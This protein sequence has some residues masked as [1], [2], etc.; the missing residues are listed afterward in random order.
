MIITITKDDGTVIETNA[1]ALARKLNNLVVH[2]MADGVLEKP[3][4]RWEDADFINC[5]IDTIDAMFYSK[6]DFLK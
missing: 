3:E 4:I 5:M 1:I 2:N 6:E